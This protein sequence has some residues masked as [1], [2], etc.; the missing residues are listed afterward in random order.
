M[1]IAIDTNLYLLCSL[2]NVSY[3][4]ISTDYSGMSIDEILEKEKEAGNVQAE[5]FDKEVLNNPAKLIQLLQLKNPANKFAI[6]SN[7]NE[8]DLDDLLPLLSQEDMAIGLNYFTKEKIL[9]LVQE[10]PKNQLVIYTLQMFSPEQIMMMMPN[11]EMNKVL[12]STEMKEMK[13]LEQTML[14]T[15]KP[16]ILAQ[17]IEAATGEKAKGVGE[18]GLDGKPKFDRAALLQQLMEM[19]DDQFQESLLSIPETNKQFFMLGMVK[20][21]PQ[22]LTLFSADAYTKMMND[23]KEKADLVKYANVIEGEQLVKMMQQLPKELT[24]V[25]LTQIDTDKFT[26]V[27]MK[28]F[29]DVL[30]QIVAC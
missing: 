13:G 10:L 30:G 9:N 16:E 26:E 22:I 1:G 15:L 8:S 28:N 23:K 18:I 27:L 21:K 25:V 6:L 7:L 3:K 14:Q 24:A 4:K 12:Q 29:R 2:I 20:E 19:D 11:E 5:Q 17:M